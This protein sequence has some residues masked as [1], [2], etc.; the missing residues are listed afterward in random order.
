MVDK[1]KASEEIRRVG[2]MLSALMEAADALGE[3]GSLE[4]AAQ[5]A[6][7]R[8]SK[9]QEA[10]KAAFAEALRL[11]TEAGENRADAVRV[12]NAAIAE[13]Q[14]VVEAA[15]TEAERIINDAKSRAIEEADR[16]AAETQSRIDDL[17]EV[18][19]AALAASEEATATA[20]TTAAELAA[21]E[22]QLAEA[23]EALAALRAK[24]S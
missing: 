16:I 4:Q 22:R 10:E 5:E 23:R 21:V 19:R 20:V 9:A 7:G 8:L 1:I 12:R 18:E 14:G 17:R 13:A 6:E 15:G 2:R 3:V 11:T 24:L